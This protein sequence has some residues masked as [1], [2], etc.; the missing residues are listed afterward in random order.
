MMADATMQ[1]KYAYKQCMNS[2]TYK[3][4]GELHRLCDYHRRKANSLQKIYATKRRHERKLERERTV[5]EQVVDPL[6]FCIP[7][8][9]DFSVKDLGIDLSDL[10]CLFDD[11]STAFDTITIVSM[12]KVE[13]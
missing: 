2:R 4:D 11:A 8:D 7:A 9:G 12:H 1:C 13:L 6:P 10:I 5:H 3:R